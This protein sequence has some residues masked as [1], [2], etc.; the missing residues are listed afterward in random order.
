MRASTIVYRSKNDDGNYVNYPYPDWDSSKF[1][2][3]S[4][5]LKR[6]ANSKRNLHVKFDILT[7]KNLNEVVH[8]GSKLLHIT[9]NIVR[10]DHSR[11]CFEDRF[12]EC[13]VLKMKQYSDM[14]RQ[15]QVASNIEVVGIAIPQS[16]DIGEVFKQRGV[17]HVLCF[18]TKEE[19]RESLEE[20]YPLI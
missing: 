8:R 18:T 13:K 17:K 9:S 2:F 1:P 12:G 10:K 7:K 20:E 6:L 16:L 19:R 11:L 15:Y 14:L 4:S 3:V 5:V